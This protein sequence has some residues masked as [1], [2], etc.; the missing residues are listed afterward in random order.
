VELRQLR[1]FLCVAETGSFSKAAVRLSVTQ[2]VLSREVRMLEEEFGEQ[3]FYRNGRGVVLSTAGELLAG[4]ARSMVEI[5]DRLKAD[6]A[7]RR[8]APSGKVVIAMPPSIGWV[9]TVPL[10][11]RCLAAYPGIS[12]HAV[13]GFSGHV[14][15][16][17]ATGRIDI[18][19]VYNAPKHPTLL[20]EPLLE[21]ELILLGPP[22]DPAGLG[23]GPVKA[24]RL[25]SVPLIMPAR[26]HGLRVQVD[27][28]MNQAGVTLR[29]EHEMD[30]MSSTLSLVEAG[31]GY[32]ILCY[33]ATQPR[34][35]ANRL[36]WWPLIDPPLV[37]HL[38]L[39]TAVQRPM[40]TAAK[41]V[42]RLVRAL[43]GE[44]CWTPARDD[45]QEERA[46]VPEPAGRS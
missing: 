42:I 29:I 24:E 1:H 38:M 26:P 32:T 15:E 20:M 21:E 39:A 14:L 5:S 4:H 9:L 16:W 6:M 44:L 25:A 2:P 41:L 45:P 31:V 28:E 10:V 17:L 43:V 37:R 23:E 46:R 13:E 22:D 3:L 12:L 35:S 19:I 30:A 40:T 7:A 8:D 36:R 27:Q 34:I 11:Q 18:G 33:A